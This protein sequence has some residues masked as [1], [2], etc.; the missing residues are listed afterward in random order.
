MSS[1]FLFFSFVL[2]FFHSLSAFTHFTLVK[3]ASSFHGV[4]RYKAFV[5]FQLSVYR[6]ITFVVHF[7]F[8]VWQLHSAVGN[9][10]AITYHMLEK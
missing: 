9:V 5:L 10:L 3:V 2:F 6:I 7:V 8:T 1:V 4:E